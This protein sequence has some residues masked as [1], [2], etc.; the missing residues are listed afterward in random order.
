MS[1]EFYIVCPETKKKLWIGQGSY[2]DMKTFYKNAYYL[3][4]LADFLNSHLG[5]A[6]FVAN[7][8]DELIDQLDIE[9]FSMERP[10]SIP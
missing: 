7:S 10:P 4:V 8:E 5:K 1:M 9:N 6:L 3:S 2:N